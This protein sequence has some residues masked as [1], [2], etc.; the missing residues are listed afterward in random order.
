MGRA[1]GIVNRRMIRVSSAMLLA[2]VMI[3]PGVVAQKSYHPGATDSEIKI[4][5]IATYTG[6]ANLSRVHCQLSGVQA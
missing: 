1:T 4:G 5:N 3:A 2:G 6:W